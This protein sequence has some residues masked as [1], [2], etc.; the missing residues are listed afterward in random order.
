MDVALIP[1]DQTIQ[2]AIGLFVLRRIEQRTQLAQL[3]EERAAQ[4]EPLSADVEA[5]DA[6]AHE[7]DVRELALRVALFEVAVE[8]HPAVVVLV[9]EVRTAKHGPSLL[10]GDPL[11]PLQDIVR[12]PRPPILEPL[13]GRLVAVVEDAETERLGEGERGAGDAEQLGRDRMVADREGLEIRIEQ[14]DAADLSRFADESFDLIF[15]P[16]SNVFFPDLRPVWREAFR[17]LGRG[18]VMLAGF[19]NPVIFMFDFDNEDESEVMKAKYALPY[20]DLTSKGPE[21][22]KKQ[23]EAN[24]PIEFGHTLEQQIGGQI[25]AGFLI[26]GFYEDHW[27]DDATILNRMTATS[28]ATKALKP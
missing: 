26:T 4:A 25:D 11:H 21:S 8:L 10:E 27:S 12:D 23:M 9:V 13:A 24:I 7:V 28:M 3:T 19:M 17:V 6:R 15:H 5:D 16:V 2:R 18:G 22:L 14:G 20:S 1:P